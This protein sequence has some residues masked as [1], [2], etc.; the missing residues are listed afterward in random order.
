[1]M[2]VPA[3]RSMSDHRNAAISPRRKPEKRQ[4]PCGGVPIA[5]DVLKHLVHFTRSQRSCSFWVGGNSGNERCRVPDYVTLAHLVVEDGGQQREHVVHCAGLPWF[6]SFHV[7]VGR[8]P[9]RSAITRSSMCCFVRS[10]TAMS[11]S[12][13]ATGVSDVRLPCT[14]DG[15]SPCLAANQSSTAWCTVSRLGCTYIPCAGWP[16]MSASASRA[17]RSVAYRRRNCLRLPSTKPVSTVN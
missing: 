11:P 16:R 7:G 9:A 8:P 12:S 13:T 1:M 15:F 6:A 5:F 17:S 3:L 14:V 4:M 10:C 2:I